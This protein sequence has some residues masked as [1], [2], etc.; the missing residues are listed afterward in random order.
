MYTA[1]EVVKTWLG[2]RI[3]A[4]NAEGKGVHLRISRCGLTHHPSVQDEQIG[5]KYYPFSGKQDRLKRYLRLE[6]GN[7]G[8]KVT[9]YLSVNGLQIY[10]PRFLVL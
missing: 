1:Q 2:W 5:S 7:R 9:H 10:G 4:K 3:K 8:G 6:V